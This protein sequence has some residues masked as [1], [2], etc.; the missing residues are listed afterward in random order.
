MANVR[1]PCELCFGLLLVWQV[2]DHNQ[3]KR[4]NSSDWLANA[5]IENHDY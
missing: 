3:P 1:R 5:T 2:T 4:C